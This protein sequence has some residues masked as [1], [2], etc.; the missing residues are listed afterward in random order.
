MNTKNGKVRSYPQLFYYSFTSVCV[1]NRLRVD[2][3][4]DATDCLFIEA[5]ESY[6][7]Y[8]EAPWVILWRYMHFPVLI[9]LVIVRMK[10]K[11]LF[12]VFG[13]NKDF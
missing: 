5:S 7:V 10:V 9:I 2:G 3:A 13:C 12:K 8:F 11:V 4:L 1:Y 6:F